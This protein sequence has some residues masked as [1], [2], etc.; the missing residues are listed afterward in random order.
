MI[1]HFFINY[2]FI[3]DHHKIMS[4]RQQNHNNAQENIQ[5]HNRSIIERQLSSLSIYINIIF[6][7]VDMVYLILYGTTNTCS[8]PINKWLLGHMIGCILMVCTVVYRKIYNIT[9]VN[10]RDNIHHMNWKAL[11]NTLI[12]VLF[13]LGNI[14]LFRSNCKDLEPKVY[15]YIL[16][17]IIINYAII[18][19]PCVLVLGICCCTPCI[20]IFGN[21]LDDGVNG[22]SP[23]QIQQLNT[24]TYTKN[25]NSNIN[26]FCENDVEYENQKNCS[27][28]LDDYNDDDQIKILP[29]KHNFHVDCVDPW[30]KK[31]FT[32]PE[33]RQRPSNP[34]E[35]V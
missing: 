33:C 14:W 32:C 31:N 12:I 21:F 3:N 30:L 18:F 7:I 26:S 22:G 23:D 16:G 8:K 20:I 29:C 4:N 19:I 15:K 2:Y 5:A 35:N 24:M 1:N 34:A 27:I 9:S 11:L 6:I 10:E 13:I 25:N 17:I 28:C